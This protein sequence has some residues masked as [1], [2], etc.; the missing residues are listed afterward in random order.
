[1]IVK[2]PSVTLWA[3]KFVTL[4]QTLYQHNMSIN[5]KVHIATLYLKLFAK[6][7]HRLAYMHVNCVEHN[8]F[9]SSR[10]QNPFLKGQFF[11]L[12]SVIFIMFNSYIKSTH[13]TKTPSLI[14]FLHYSVN[15]LKN[16]GLVLQFHV[17]FCLFSM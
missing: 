12:I 8:L 4:C 15:H 1:M 3:W 16:L 17:Y 7:L 11:Y 6:K 14:V 13:D 10:F 9:Q 5:C 2:T